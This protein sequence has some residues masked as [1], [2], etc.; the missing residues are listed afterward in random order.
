[1]N[2]PNLTLSIRVQLIHRY[3][4]IQL[5]KVFSVEL[6]NSPSYC[7]VYYFIIFPEHSKENRQII[8]ERN[9]YYVEMERMDGIYLKVVSGEPALEHSEQ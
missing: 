8:K 1:M 3:V 2:I 5:F 4:A 9:D 6:S 7:I